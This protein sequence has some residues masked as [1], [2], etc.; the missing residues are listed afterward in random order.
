VQQIN[1]QNYLLRLAFEHLSKEEDEF[2]LLA[3]SW[4]VNLRRLPQD[5]QV[6]AKKA[7]NYILFEAELGT[8]TRG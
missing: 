7:I 8:S 4:A 2:E 6:L 1:L 5:Q 3:K